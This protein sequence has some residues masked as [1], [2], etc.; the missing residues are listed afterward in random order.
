M[1]E[2]GLEVYIYADF[3]GNWYAKEYSDHDKVRSGHG[4][5]IM[6]GGLPMLWKSQLQTDIALSITETDYTGLYYTLRDA[7]HILNLFKE[8]KSFDVLIN[9]S[10]AILHCKV[11]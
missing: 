8:M 7:I 9:S 3:A 2:R 11:F 6:Y 4:Y 10:K 1:K 5:F